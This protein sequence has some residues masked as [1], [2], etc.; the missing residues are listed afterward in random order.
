MADFITRYFR[1]K[2]L[3]AAL[4]PVPTEEQNDAEPVIESTEVKTMM[5]LVDI[6]DLSW[7]DVRNKALEV[8]FQYCLNGQVV[9]ILPEKLDKKAVITTPP[10]QTLTLND[11]TKFGKPVGDK[12]QELVG[13]KVDVLVNLVLNSDYMMEYI[14]KTSPARFK[15]GRTEFGQNGYDMLLEDPADTPLSP[16]ES[17]NAIIDYLDKMKWKVL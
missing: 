9:F 11:M 16:L 15:I 5:V 8:F 4:A 1:E 2:N 3:K 7:K 17:F 13:R 6:R 10:D 12:I 14:V